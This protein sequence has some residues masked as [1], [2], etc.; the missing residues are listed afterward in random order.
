M[1]LG[2]DRA[3]RQAEQGEGFLVVGH[4]QETVAGRAHR[5]Q[6][7]AVVADTADG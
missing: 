6:D 2:R 5:D 3:V 4:G 7:L 1:Q